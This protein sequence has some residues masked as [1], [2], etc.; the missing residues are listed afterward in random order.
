M[1]KQNQNESRNREE[2]MVE[3]VE[4]PW[5]KS[6]TANN[7]GKVGKFVSGGKVSKKKRK[8]VSNHER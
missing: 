8:R 5:D 4:I 2:T 1:L 6:K 7:T 3:L